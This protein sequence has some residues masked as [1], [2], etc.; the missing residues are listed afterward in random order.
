MRFLVLG[1][2]LQGFAAALD[3]ARSREVE[4][5]VVADSDGARAARAAERLQGLNAAVRAETIDVTK[6][7]RLVERLRGYDVVI[8]AVP[9]F[10]N[11]DLT[12]AAIANGTLSRSSG[13]SGKAPAGGE[14]VQAGLA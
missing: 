14:K 3:L 4:E 8:S 1:A 2:G 10:L 7:S 5:V 12:K 13:L 9:Y 6:E 11:L